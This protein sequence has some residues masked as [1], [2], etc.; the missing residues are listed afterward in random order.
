MEYR[1]ATEQDT[2][3]IYNLVQTTITTVYPRYYPKE[4]VDFFCALHNEEAIRTDILAGNAGVLLAE[5]KIVGTGS[6]QG[7]H[8]TRVYV[9][10]KFQGKG[11]GSFIMEQLEMLIGAAY[12]KAE[13]DA[14][15][16]A[17]NLYEKRGYKTV[18]HA[19][20]NVENGV[21]LVYEIME[22][23][24]H[25]T[26]GYDGKCFVPKVNSE[27]GEIDGQTMFHYHQNESLNLQG[28]M[29][30]I[31]KCTTDDIHNLAVLNK[32]LIDDEKAKIL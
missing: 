7:N 2:A 6:Y 13:L 25:T 11:Y 9:L 19:K 1:K 24:F 4:V 16:P 5:G 28:E 10:P 20:W 31:K 15:L 29:I 8:I 32:Q 3:Q 22:K 18:K 30:H 14:S 17:C 26:Y 27:N 23:E 12:E 21:V